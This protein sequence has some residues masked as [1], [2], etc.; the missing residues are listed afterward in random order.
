VGLYELQYLV[1]AFGC[2]SALIRRGPPRAHQLRRR[3]SRTWRGKENLLTMKVGAAK[4]SPVMNVRCG[5]QS[6]SA[7]VLSLC[8]DEISP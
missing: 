8:A 1:V 2:Q 3:E 5:G 7:G 6:A 4:S